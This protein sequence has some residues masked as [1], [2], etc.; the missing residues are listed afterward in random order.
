MEPG[1]RVRFLKNGTNRDILDCMDSK[2]SE[3]GLSLREII[4]LPDGYDLELPPAVP[5]PTRDDEE[6]IEERWRRW[7]DI[8]DR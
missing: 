6:L 8:V 4:P 7:L 2:E 5:G 1:N 3:A